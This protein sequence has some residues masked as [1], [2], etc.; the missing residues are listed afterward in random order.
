MRRLAL[1]AAALGLLAW[2]AGPALS[3]KAFVPEARSF[4]QAVAG[5]TIGERWTSPVQ[6]AP[7]RF[8]L[9]GF[10]WAEEEEGHH[11]EEHRDEDDSGLE[12]RVRR[13]G[14]DWSPWTQAGAGHGVTGTDPVWAGGADAYQLRVDERP[15]DL[16]AQFVNATGSGTTAQRAGTAL[17]RAV[18]SAV[19][20]ALG[21]PAHAQGGG[22]NVVARE[23]WGA[24]QCAPTTQPSYGSVE[25]GMVHH[26]VSAN[27]YGPEDSAAI[28][29]AICRFHRDSNGWNDIGYN[30]LVDR[31]GTVFEGR[32]GGIDQPVI[33]AQAQGYNGRSSGVANIGTFSGEPQTAEGVRS[34]ARLLAWKLAIHG[35]PVTGRTTVTSAGGGS[36]RFASG[37]EVSFERIS[38][39]RDGNATECPGRALYAQVPEIRRQAAEIAPTISAAAT[40]P[41]TLTLAQRTLVYPQPAQLAGRLVG[42]DGAPLAGQRID[43]Q[44]RGPNGFRTL[45]RTR[46]AADGTWAAALRSA[47]SRTVRAV[48]V[49]DDGR[50]G[51]VSSVVGLR[52][53]PAIGV[54]AAQRVTAGGLVTV[55][56]SVAPR[57]GRL[58][59]ELAR[60]GSDGRY[61]TIRRVSVRSTAGRYRARVRLTRPALHRVRVTYAGDRTSAPARSL[62]HHV[63]AVRPRVATGGA[64]AR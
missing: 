61:R 60:Q 59:V 45:G 42:S 41:L 15:E 19:I 38:G 29:L 23:A 34:T 28:V 54:A 25:F 31:Y 62:D 16:R 37:R 21:T 55:S 11:E 12:V 46:T 24:E 43:L 6:R 49:L 20:T 63:R 2:A 36:N 58:R 52:V 27:S 7:E 33:G 22:P 50:R 5:G 9:L 57:K 47:L 44:I 4:E 13:D 3:L 17:R 35:Q 26:T 32:A 40:A 48:H 8:D 10:K 64:G 56:G 1:L 51:A 39:H 18:N 14:G 53:S 30:F